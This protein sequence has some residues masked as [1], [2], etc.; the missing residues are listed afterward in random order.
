[1]RGCWIRSSG[2]R[3]TAISSDTLYIGVPTFN[4]P[5]MIRETVGSLRGSEFSD[6]R[7]VVSDNRS[8]ISAQQ[9][10]RAFIEELDDPR[11]SF[12]VQPENGGEYGQGRFFMRDSQRCE[13]FAIVHD[14]DL[15]DPGCLGRALERLR[16]H[17]EAALFIANPRLID[18]A[19]EVSD[20]LTLEYLKDH[21]R[22]ERQTGL[23]PI[24]ETLLDTGF[25]PISGTVFRRECLVQSGFVDSD[26]VGNFPFELNVMLRLGDLAL[27]GWLEDETLLSVRYH[28]GSLRNTLGLMNNIAVVSTMLKLLDRREYT[29]APEARRRVL[30]ARL[31]RAMAEIH[32][33]NGA[34]A[35]AKAAIKSA[36]TTR[37]KSANAW[38]TCFKIYLE[39]ARG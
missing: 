33:K 21:G 15:L 27:Q 1:M 9:S 29:G 18:E 25:T 2:T 32:A 24:L 7:V 37:P 23:F 30:V 36:I 20:A 13:F 14:D 3:S 34:I 38:K 4:R 39:G 6:Y 22:G 28:K 35:E 10:V 12:V 11:F 16:T 31:H 8:E 5:D 17:P 26:C 19:C